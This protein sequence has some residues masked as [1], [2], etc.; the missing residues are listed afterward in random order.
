MELIGKNRFQQLNRME[1]DVCKLFKMILISAGCEAPNNA[2]LHQDVIVLL[3][4]KFKKNG[5]F[6]EFGATN[7]IDLSNTYLMEKEYDWKGILAE[8]NKTWHKDLLKNRNVNIDF[9]CV[10][11]KSNNVVEFNM[12]DDAEFS[13]IS[14][15]NNCDHHSELRKEGV[16]CCVKTISLHD[17]LEKYDAPRII[18]YLSIDTEGSEFEILKGFDF[19]KYEFS[20]I[21]CEHNYTQ[22]RDRIYN[23]LR[24]VGYVRKF[25]GLSRWDDWYFNEKHFGKI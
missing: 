19:N 23:L 11:K 9:S 12:V 21:T 15:F 1:R 5:Y 6:V 18:D 10:W 24:N 7:G 17:L 22:N 25:K 3:A 13:T 20:I 16:T 14:K 2:Q 4:T 8:P